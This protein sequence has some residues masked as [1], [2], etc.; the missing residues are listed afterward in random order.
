MKGISETMQDIRYKAVIFDLDGTLINS[1][2]DLGSA[3]NR[4][5]EANGFPAHELDEYNNF[6]GDGAEMMIRRALPENCRDEQTVTRCLEQFLEDYFDNYSVYTKPY[7]G[8]PQLL[9]FLKEKNV[10]IQKTHMIM[11]RMKR[12]MKVKKRETVHVLIRSG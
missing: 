1:V 4:T 11:K 9:D 6:I 2:E 10:I 5:L 12:V 7:D 8:I 3:V